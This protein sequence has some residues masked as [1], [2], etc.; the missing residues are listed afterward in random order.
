[1]FAELAGKVM[2]VDKDFIKSTTDFI[3]AE[4]TR[5]KEE[6]SKWKNIKVYDTQ[7]NFF[8]VEILRDDVTSD[9]IFH[10]LIQKNFS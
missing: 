1:M 3:S 8:L 5:I 6:L 2:F 7:S 9:E 4:R 10:N